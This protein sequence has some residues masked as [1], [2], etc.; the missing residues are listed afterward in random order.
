MAF[1]DNFSN[2]RKFARNIVLPI[3]EIN[4]SLGEVLNKADGGG[5]IIDFGSGTFFWSDK[6][7]DNFE[8]SNVCA[9]DVIYK[10]NPS[11]IK[12]RDR[13]TVYSDIFEC[14]GKENCGVFFACDV[15]HHL[16][17]DLWDNIFGE[18]LKRANAVFIKDID[19]NH[20]FGNKMNKLHDKVINK[21]IIEDVNPLKLEEKLKANGF[22][23]RYRYV[24]KL[25][26]PHFILT[27]IKTDKAQ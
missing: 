24:P 17:P 13:L 6:I 4:S 2:L 7:L 5:K 15:I 22:E 1:D 26:Y 20:P 18:A 21:E 19:C 12:E 16:D 11:L 27:G 23:T 9:V 25:W 10:S 3:N 14:L 8:T